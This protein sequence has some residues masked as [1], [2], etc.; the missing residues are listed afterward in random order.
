MF[1]EYETRF[2]GLE[3]Q[4]LQKPCTITDLLKHWIQ[5]LDPWSVKTDKLITKATVRPKATTRTDKQRVEI[6]R[7]CNISTGQNQSSSPTW[8]GI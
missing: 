5:K 4:A 6:R 8:I 3:N 1:K 7:K 2:K